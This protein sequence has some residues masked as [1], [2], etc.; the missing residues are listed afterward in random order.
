MLGGSPWKHWLPEQL[1]QPGFPRKDGKASREPSIHPEASFQGTTPQEN[2]TGNQ[3]QIEKRQWKNKDE[4][5]R[6]QES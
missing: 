1:C 4:K 6:R 3:V 2:H 5:K